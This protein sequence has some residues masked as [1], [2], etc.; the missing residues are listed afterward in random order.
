MR[1]ASNLS[2]TTRPGTID[3]TIA[4]R[5]APA[6]QVFNG[7]VTLL[8]TDDVSHVYRFEYKGKIREKY[9]MECYMQSL[10]QDCGVTCSRVLFETGSRLCDGDE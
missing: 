4:A 7:L 5:L 6:L 3:D 1:L 10:I 9:G 8:E 2:G